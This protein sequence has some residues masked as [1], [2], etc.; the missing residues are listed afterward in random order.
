MSMYSVDVWRN[1]QDVIVEKMKEMDGLE[2]T[3]I[4]IYT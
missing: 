2:A 4:R 3:S 1:V